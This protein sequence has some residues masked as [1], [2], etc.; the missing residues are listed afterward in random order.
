MCV[1]YLLMKGLKKLVD[2]GIRI[3]KVGVEIVYAKSLRKCPCD[4][5]LHVTFL[6]FLSDFFYLRHLV[7][8]FDLSQRV[9]T[10]LVYG[11]F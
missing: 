8:Y 4:N 1:L 9:F 3:V 6:A 7:A 5:R 11:D 10:I 2:S